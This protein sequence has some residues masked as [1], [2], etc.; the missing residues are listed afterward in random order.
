LATGW[1]WR[2]AA[3]EPVVLVTQQITDPQAAARSI[4]QR[5]LFGDGGAATGSAAAPAARSFTLLGAMTAGGRQPGFA[6]LS[7]PG[8]TPVAVLEGEEITPGVT[9]AKVSANK[10]TIVRNGQNETLE[11]VTR[12]SS[13][14]PTP[15]QNSAAPRADAA[16]APP[17]IPPRPANPSP[18]NP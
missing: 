17:A 18:Q 11:L 8:K 6:I 14:A 5:H 7:E 13:S 10:V 15:V 16:A 12:P 3:P 9:L 2:L 4:S 1:F